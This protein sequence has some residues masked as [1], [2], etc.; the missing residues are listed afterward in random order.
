MFG[1][2][3]G[4]YFL[5][6]VTCLLLIAIITEVLDREEKEQKKSKQ[7]TREIKKQLK[8]RTNREETKIDID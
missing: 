3:I 2:E 7:L 1:I 6:F 4:F 5:G 8:I